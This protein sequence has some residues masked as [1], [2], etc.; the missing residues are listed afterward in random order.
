MS[1]HSARVGGWLGRSGLAG[2]PW[3]VKLFALV[4]FVA[5]FT[6]LTWG[7]HRLGL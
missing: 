5:I 4:V 3:Y 6:A 2:Q 7:Q 1:K